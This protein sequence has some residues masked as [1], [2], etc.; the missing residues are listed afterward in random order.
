MF[1]PGRKSKQFFQFLP[2]NYMQ[3][4]KK[5]TEDELAWQYQLQ[6]EILASW[7][8]CEIVIN[9]ALSLVGHGYFHSIFLDNVKKCF[10]I[11]GYI[12][13]NLPGRIELFELP[14]LK[15]GDLNLKACTFKFLIVLILCYNILFYFNLYNSLAVANGLCIYIIKNQYWKVKN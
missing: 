15:S 11:S 12:G 13:E 2:P 7:N 5:M 10:K 14:I 8:F 4:F 6:I 3:I 1:K 9:R